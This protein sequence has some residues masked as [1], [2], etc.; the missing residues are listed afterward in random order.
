MYIMKKLNIWFLL[1]LLFASFLILLFSINIFYKSEYPIHY[2]EYVEKYSLKFNVD[3]HLIYSIIRSESS[4]D[5]SAKSYVGAKGLMQITDETYFWLIDKLGEKE[6]KDPENLYNA[7][8]NIKYGTYFIKLLLDEFKD[9]KT[10]L[11]AYH[12]GRGNVNKW[13]TD[14]KYSSNGQLLTIPFKD[15]NIY[16]N[17]TIKTYD[18]YTKIYKK[19]GNINVKY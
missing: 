6:N 1:I 11:S 18:I 9:T 10:A 19:R 17:K 5:Y 8:N 3:K 16:A 13:I 7:E 2:E 15:T 12:A 14:S 4:F